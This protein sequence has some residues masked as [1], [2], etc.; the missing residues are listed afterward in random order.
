MLNRFAFFILIFSTLSHSQAAGSP[1]SEQ[2]QGKQFIQ[3]MTGEYDYSRAQLERIFSHVRPNATILKKISKPAEK[4]MPWFKYRRIFSD[5]AR[6]TNGTLFYKKYEKVLDEAYDQYGVPPSIIVAILGVETRYGKVMGNDY[7]IEAL[8]T[9]AFGYP[10]R[11]EFFTKELRAYLRM[12]KE[13]GIDPLSLKGS[14]AGAMGMAQF[15][16]SSY[17]HYAVDY[18]KDGKRDLW[19]T[20]E[21]AIF[22]IA[23]YLSGNGWVREGLIA[24]EA[25]L[26]LPYSGGYNHKP[27]V[28]LASLKAQGI[29]TLHV[30]ANPDEKVGLLQLQ[31]EKA[32][33]NFITFKNFSV[34]TTYNTSPMYAMAVFEL[35][36][37]IEEG[38]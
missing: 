30:L 6:I 27:F 20:P 31:G 36:K 24:D 12:T 17:L 21:D 2:A 23:H 25:E 9:I 28:T 10:K 26:T 13:E 37:S 11:S 8:S 33:L 1:Y 18:D 22:S 4:T 7:V 38:L 19:N 32:P 29:D 15:M 35:A 16:P 14:Y 3:T 5:R 34:I